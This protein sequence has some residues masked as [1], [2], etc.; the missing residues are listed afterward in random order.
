MSPIENVW[1]MM[2]KEI[3]KLYPRNMTDLKKYMR[4]I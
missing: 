1:G 2:E 4:I 3:K